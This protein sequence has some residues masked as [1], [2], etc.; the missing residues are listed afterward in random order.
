MKVV[1]QCAGSKRGRCWTWQGKSLQFVAHPELCAPSEDCLYVRPD[2]SIPGY[3]HTWREGL[4]SYNGLGTNPDGLSRA[5]DLYKRNEYRA[6]ADAFGW[7]NTFILSAGWGLVR[8]DFL[9]PSYDITFSGKA[10]CIKRTANDDYADYNQLASVETA[11]DETIYFFGGIS[12]L[13]LYYDLTRFLPRRKVVYFTAKK[14]PRKQGYHYI[15][16]GKPFT[17]WH[18]RCATDFI[19]GKIPR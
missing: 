7:E 19:Y 18:Y 4:G 14:T 3:G 16:Y 5:A 13:S 17:N 11:T 1:I 9:L 15:R 10:P 8:S 6:L 2:D 12:Y